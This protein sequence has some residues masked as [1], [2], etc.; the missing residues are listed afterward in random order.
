MGGSP[1]ANGA[2]F[3]EATP[4][5]EPVLPKLAFRQHPQLL[6]PLVVVQVREE[7]V[8]GDGLGQRRHGLI[9]LGDDLRGGQVKSDR[10]H[11]RAEPRA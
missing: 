8:L 9:V 6:P 2:S 7:H 1:G 3:L 5:R 10:Q 11:P 4:T